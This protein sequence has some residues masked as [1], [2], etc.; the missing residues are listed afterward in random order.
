[1]EKHCLPGC[2][3]IGLCGICIDKSVIFATYVN[4]LKLNHK[5]DYETFPVR[6][7]GFAWWGKVLMRLKLIIIYENVDFLF[8]G[9]NLGYYTDVR[10]LFLSENV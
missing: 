6:I 8:A 2:F 1:M 4:A 9:C 10:F 7:V 5:T 3:S